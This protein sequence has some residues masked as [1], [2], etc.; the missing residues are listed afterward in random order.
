MERNDELRELINAFLGYRELL[1][2]LQENLRDFAESYQSIQNDLGK[3]NNAFE[4]N[5]Q[6]K[7]TQIMNN[8]SSQAEKAAGLSSRID[9]FV[10]ETNRYTVTMENML[11]TFDK[12]EKAVS[13]IVKIEE[14]AETQ[15]KKIE[16][17][18]EEKKKS[19]NVTQLQRSLENYNQNLQAVSEFINKDVAKAL[20]N[21]AKKL[22]EIKGSEA[23][24]SKEA[25]QT[26]ASLK[27]L[28]AEQETTN[29]FLKKIT[30]KGDVD[31]TYLYDVLDRWATARRV[32][33]KK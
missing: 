28:V 7:L 1:A 31:E 25:A 24:L 3:L 2:P 23:N 11:G 27:Q 5:V 29:A 17:I 4:G 21:N 12:V 22:D 26:S 6:G 30:E 8:L 33:T 20:E 13:S 19:Y 32:K 18:A 16:G 14:A 15:L 9:K 10:S